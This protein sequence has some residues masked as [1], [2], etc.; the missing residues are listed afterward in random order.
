M[1]DLKYDIKSA[2]ASCLCACLSLSVQI[3]REAEAA[4]FHRQLF[5]ELRRTSH[6]TRDPTES[7][8]MGAVEASFKCCASAIVVLTKSGRSESTP[9]HAH[10]Y[11]HIH[12]YTCTRAHT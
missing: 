5:E 4:M 2:L 10:T 8:A 6:L 7:V 12:T 3:C 9:T 11:T 1:H